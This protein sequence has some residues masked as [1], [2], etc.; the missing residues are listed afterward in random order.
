MAKKTNPNKVPKTKADC[1][2]AWQKGVIDGVSNACAIFLTVLLDKFDGADHIQDV[3]R[4]INKLSEEVR[5]KRVSVSDLRRVLAEE[6][7][8]QV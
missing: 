4:E 6:Y 1:D 3:W 8:V 2:R 7:G 5:E